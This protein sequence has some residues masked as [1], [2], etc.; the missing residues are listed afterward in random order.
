MSTKENTSEQFNPNGPGTKGCLFGMPFSTEQSQLVIVPVPWEVTVTQRTGTAHAPK[1]ILEA[2]Y[3]IDLFS[4]FI[5]DV[6]KLGVGMLPFSDALL[7]ES[8]KLRLLAAQ[9]IRALENGEVIGSDNILTAKINEACEN[10]N[11]YVKNIAKGLLR[12]GKMVGILG[13]D[14]STCLGF[15]RALSEQYDRFGILQIDAHADL[16]RK[17]QG[18]TYSHASIMHNALKL[19]TVERLIQVGVRDYCE[20]EY[21]VIHRSMGRVKTFFDE[22]LKAGWFAGKTWES[23]CRGV[24]DELPEYVYISFDIDGLDPG[25][26][27]NTGTPVPGGLTFDQIKFLLTLVA[28]SGKKII[29]FDLNE[30]SGEHLWDAQVGARI[31]FELCNATAVSNGKLKFSM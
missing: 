3:Q 15:L 4:K 21:Q 16:R 2:S 11:T 25:L 1:A 14:H 28:C 12:E 19:P 13:G 8:N 17:Y 7:D 6:W 9:Q 22:D 29:G 23:I 10:L 26:C 24:I 27:P 30:V 31:L 18:F 5:S 20:E